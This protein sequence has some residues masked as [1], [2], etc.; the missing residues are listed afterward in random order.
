MA[1]ED[2]GVE[3]DPREQGEAN[4]RQMGGKRPTLALNS[5]PRPGPLQCCAFDEQLY[6]EEQNGQCLPRGPH[7]KIRIGLVSSP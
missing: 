5:G 4:S 6:V 7:T 3:L 1:A 2:T